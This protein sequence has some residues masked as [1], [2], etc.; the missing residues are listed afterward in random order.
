MK[1]ETR[2]AVFDEELRV[3]A[4]RFEGIVQAF[5]NHFHEHYVIGLVES[6]QRRLSCRDREAMLDLAEEVTGRRKLP[7][8]SRSV[9]SDEE[10]ACCL[11][12]FHE[13]VMRGS[14]ELEKEEALLLLVS[15]LIR[16]YGQPFED[17]VPE[18]RAEIEK[19]CAFMEQHYAERIY[20]EQICR[21]AGLSKSA[22]IRAFTR[23]KGVTPYRYLENIRVGRAKELLEQGVPPIEAALRTGFS[24]QSHFTNYWSRLIGLTPGAYGEI[25][26]HTEGKEH[27]K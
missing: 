22:L 15:L 12:S 27:A 10:A 17:C 20:L 26:K 4:Y 14:G 1:K 7:G 13:L 25:F 5:P 16:R 8:F 3:E 2:T 6:G 24:D 19:A 9:V 18:C 21:C 23:S 11:R